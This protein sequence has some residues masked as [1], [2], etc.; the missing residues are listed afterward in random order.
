MAVESE[1]ELAARQLLAEG[2]S[3][4]AVARA[5]REWERPKVVPIDARCHCGRPLDWRT[6][7]GGTRVAECERHGIRRWQ[8]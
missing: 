8:A 4:V 5:L 7:I 6:L 2:W 3:P 1:Y